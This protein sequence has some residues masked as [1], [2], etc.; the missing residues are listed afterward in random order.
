MDRLENF[1]V[2]FFQAAIVATILGVL[3]QL[4]VDALI[5]EDT[6]RVR[7]LEQ[8]FYQVALARSPAY[9]TSARPSPSDLVEPKTRVFQDAGRGK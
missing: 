6:A 4:A 2:R 3:A 5:A 7:A 9:P 8:H 1:L